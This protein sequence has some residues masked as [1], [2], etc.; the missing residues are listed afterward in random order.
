MLRLSQAFVFVVPALVATACPMYENGCDDSGDCA[1][2]YACT[3]GSC[4]SALG[5]VSVP[6]DPDTPP[7][8][9]TTSDCD[10]GFVCDRYKRCVPEDEAAGAGGMSGGAGV[11]SGGAN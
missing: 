6:P 3:A 11:P 5:D 1:I 7:R 9:H 2:G 10:P 8:C 4:V